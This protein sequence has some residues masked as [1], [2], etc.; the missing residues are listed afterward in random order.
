MNDLSNMIESISKNN[1]Q[2]IKNSEKY[3]DFNSPEQVVLSSSDEAVEHAY[4]IPI[5]RTLS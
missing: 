3:F 1:Y 5:D 2:F 4:F